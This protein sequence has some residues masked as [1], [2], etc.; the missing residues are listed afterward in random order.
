MPQYRVCDAGMFYVINATFNRIVNHSTKINKINWG[1]GVEAVCGT[2]KGLVKKPGK[3]SCWPYEENGCFIN[4][5][6]MMPF[7]SPLSPLQGFG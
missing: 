4:R 1:Q 5:F 7:Y 2:A 6:L 3:H